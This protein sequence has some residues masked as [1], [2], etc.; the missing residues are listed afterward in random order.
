MLL[1]ESEESIKRMNQLT[2]RVVVS[3]RLKVRIIPVIFFVVLTLLVLSIVVVRVIVVMVHPV[4]LTHTQTKR[5]LKQQAHIN[6]D[7]DQIYFQSH[8]HS[9]FDC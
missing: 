4:F 6:N 1:K 7:G 8:S 5:K 2:V 3:V 9:R